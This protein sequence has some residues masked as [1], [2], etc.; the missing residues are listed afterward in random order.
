M[1]AIQQLKAAGVPV[2]YQIIGDGPERQR[3]LYTIQDLGLQD[4]TQ[5]LGRQPPTAVREL[6]QQA[7]AF[8]LASLSEGI[9]NV[10]LEA[11]A[12]GLP[13]VTTDCGGMREAVT[14]GVE[15]FVTPVRDPNAMA[16][17]LEKLWRDPVC[18]V[19]WETEDDNVSAASFLLR[20]KSTSSLNFFKNWP[21]LRSIGI[22]H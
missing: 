3:I 18:A 12:C 2:Q 5:L 22:R 14:D 9:A 21:S 7:D 11:M 8:L 10:V 13:V 4:C 16:Q 20:D 19:K 6:L 1:L 17:A 15:G